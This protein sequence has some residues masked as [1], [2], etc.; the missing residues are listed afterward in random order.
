MRPFS[1]TVRCLMIV[2]GNEKGEHVTICPIGGVNGN[3]WFQAETNIS[4]N[5][6][7]GNITPYFEISDLNR[8]YTQLVKLHEKLKGEAEL[9]PI[10][11]QFWLK[12]IGD[13][14]GHI[15]V[16]GIAYTHATYGSCLK[17]EFEV[18][19]THLPKLTKSLEKLIHSYA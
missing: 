16:E 3:D 2:I 14:M 6:F 15:Q 5:S 11:G 12:L 9:N 18:D 13:G 7:K 19:Q 1:S 4:V 10:E 8:F 17:F